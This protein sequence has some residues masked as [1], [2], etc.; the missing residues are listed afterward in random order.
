LD[1]KDI[2]EQGYLDAYI[3]GDLS[4]EEKVEVERA[5][6]DPLVRSEY[7]RIEKKIEVLARMQGQEPPSRLKNSVLGT[8]ADVGSRPSW[9]R[10]GFAASL[11]VGLLGIMASVFFWNQWQST[12]AQLSQLRT[13]NL[14]IASQYQRVNNN[15]QE[16]QEDIGKLINPQFKRIVM[17]GTDNLPGGEA[18]VYWNPQTQEVALNSLSLP[19]LSADEQYQLWALV[20]GKPVDAGIFDANQ[21]QIQ[22]MEL[23]AAADAFAVTIEPRGGSDTPTLEKLQVRGK[24]GSA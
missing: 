13:D 6:F 23:I 1:N 11:V 17:S 21:M 4:P 14:E 16:L 20:D 12:D 3:T 2:I 22:D 7:D 5:L 18:V 8:I 9:L 15:Y 24:V 19:A 10:V